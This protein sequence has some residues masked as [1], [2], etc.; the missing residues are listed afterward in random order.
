MRHGPIAAANPTLTA[1]VAGAVNGDTF[2]ATATTTA[3][4]SSAVGIYP[5]TPTVTGA[6][7]N[8]YTVTAANGTL[9]VS[10]AGTGNIALSST[11][12]P[13]TYG[14]HRYGQLHGRNYAAGNRHYQW[15]HSNVH[16]KHACRWIRSSNGG[17]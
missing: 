4:A 3:T 5:I 13:S 9:T 7:I 1:T 15:D 12:N 6:N 10:Q 16:D 11:P 2:T 17:L 8:D 14:R